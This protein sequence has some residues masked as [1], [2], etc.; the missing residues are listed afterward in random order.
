MRVRYFWLLLL[1]SLLVFQN[2]VLENAFQAQLPGM[3]E[4]LGGGD[5]YDGKLFVN[6]VT[7]DLCP[8]GSDVRSIIGVKADGAAEA[9]R[10][11][12]QERRNEPVTLARDAY[13][14]HNPENLIFEDKTFDRDPKESGDVRRTTWLCRGSETYDYYRIFHQIELT[15]F[16]DRWGDIIIKPKGA[17]HSARFKAAYYERGSTK[18]MTSSVFDSGEFDVNFTMDGVPWIVA[19]TLPG[20]VGVNLALVQTV[21]GTLIG[22]WLY[23]P[24]E[25]TTPP[26]GLKGLESFNLNFECRPQE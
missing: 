3:Q 25:G 18:V 14:P 17:G 10:L 26:P 23:L 4:S 24:G 2:C 5:G 11:N 16:R 15:N 22:K 21:K 12:C 7:E 19:G 9:L 20:G 13:M 1:P 6:R 8:D